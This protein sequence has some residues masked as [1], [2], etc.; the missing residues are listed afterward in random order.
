MKNERRKVKYGKNMSKEQIML[1]KLS[2]ILKKDEMDRV[3]V[4]TGEE[5]GK[6]FIVLD[7]HGW[8]AYKAR[9]ILDKIILI[10]RGEDFNIDLIHGYQHGIAIKHMLLHEYKNPRITKMRS[11]NENPGLTLLKVA[12]A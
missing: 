7:T 8:G 5:D 3:A 11:Y 1:D 12:A 10:N 2:F 6:P 9:V 4:K